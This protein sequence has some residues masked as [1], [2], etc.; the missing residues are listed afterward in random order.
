[1][2]R[3][4]I[5]AVA[6]GLMALAPSPAVAQTAIKSAF[7]KN[8]Y[9]QMK[10]KPVKRAFAVSTNGQIC[11]AVWGL[12]SQGAANSQ[13]RAGCQGNGERSCALVPIR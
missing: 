9:A 3:L 2:R 6:A 8:L 11:H 7:C 13:A 1:M 4:I 10:R 12:H 5:L